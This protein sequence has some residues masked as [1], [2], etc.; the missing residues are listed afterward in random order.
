MGKCP[1]L[2]QVPPGSQ[3]KSK[4]IATLAKASKVG[5]LPYV[6][7]VDYCA[8]LPHQHH[9]HHHY[10]HHYYHYPISVQTLTWPWA[11]SSTACT[12]S[13]CQ[14]VASPFGH[15][16]PLTP[17]RPPGL[18]LHQWLFDPR[19]ISS[20]AS[21]L[22]PISTSPYRGRA[23]PSQISNTHGSA[24]VSPST[25]S[26]TPIPHRRSSNPSKGSKGSFHLELLN[27]PVHK[28]PCR[29]LYRSATSFT[30]PLFSTLLSII[31]MS[32][33]CYTLS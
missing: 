3:H 22:P 6:A 29:K 31:Q 2:S 19:N 25:S 23:A 17:L 21:F 16:I 26:P 30:L 4:S 11:F 20:H 33:C 12:Q 15:P 27:S 10:H 14:L 18:D 28:F 32:F 13:A 8:V 24:F 7:H 1:T 5:T 9:Y